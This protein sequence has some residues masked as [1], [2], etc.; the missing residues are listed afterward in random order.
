MHST[1]SI[2]SGKIMKIG[3]KSTSSTLTTVRCTSCGKE[4]DPAHLLTI[5]SCGKVLYAKYDLE[6]A[7][8]YITKDMRGRRFDIWRMHEIMPVS[9]EKNR[10]TLGE[11][12]TPLF[13][14][15]QT[16]QVFSLKNLFLKDEGQNP[17]GTFKSRG[18]CAA[19]SKSLNVFPINISFTISITFQ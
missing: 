2:I 9:D 8:E 11:G 7:K 12:W 19:V 6:E 14:L 4:Y 5:C 13:R 10:F 15:P 16:G 18:L 1:L 17:T 3:K